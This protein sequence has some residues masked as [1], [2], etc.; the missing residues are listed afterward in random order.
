MTI[1]FK[2]KKHFGRVDF[3][4]LNETARLLVDMKRLNT[5]DYVKCLK[6]G[7]IDI[8]KK[9]GF[10]VKIIQDLEAI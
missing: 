5:G 9:M 4:P 2:I 6:R 10:E 1:E 7:E 3:Y 8:L